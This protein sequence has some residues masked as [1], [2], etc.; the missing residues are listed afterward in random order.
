LGTGE[1]P[2]ADEPE[3]SESVQPEMLSQSGE[4]LIVRHGSSEVWRI[5]HTKLDVLLVASPGFADP[6]YY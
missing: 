4:P 3:E 5:D 6:D 1:L 2:G